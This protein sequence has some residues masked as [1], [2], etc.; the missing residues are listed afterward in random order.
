MDASNTGY[1]APCEANNEEWCPPLETS[2]FGSASILTCAVEFN[3]SGIDVDVGSLP[4]SDVVETVLR[5]H[6]I[7][8]TAT[9]AIHTIQVVNNA[10]VSSTPA[11]DVD[12]H[13][14]PIIV[15]AAAVVVIAAAIAIVIRLRQANPKSSISPA[16]TKWLGSP[17]HM[18][19]TG[20]SGPGESKRRLLGYPVEGGDSKTSPS[21]P[22][23]AAP[24][25][26]ASSTLYRGG[27]VTARIN[28]GGKGRGSI[29]PAAPPAR[30][31]APLR[32]KSTRTCTP[33]QFDQ[34]LDA[35][36]L[37]FTENPV[38]HDAVAAAG[39]PPP[40]GRRVAI[41]SGKIEESSAPVSVS[42]AAVR[43][44]SF[45][46][47]NAAGPSKLTPGMLS[48]QNPLNVSVRTFVDTG[49]GN[50]RYMLPQSSRR[51]VKNKTSLTRG[52]G[53]L[54]QI[55]EPSSAAPARRPSGVGIPGTTKRK[56][57]IAFL[58]QNATG[59][60]TLSSARRQSIRSIITPSTPS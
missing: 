9:I 5:N 39:S 58:P 42:A 55:I 48:N 27:R 53:G 6:S 2:S 43:R 35:S 40:T 51:E 37:E 7:D 19:H 29:A 4:L 50:R 38:A 52:R 14:L 54:Q 47:S 17:M 30:V 18:P 44:G 23:R 13:F 16:P 26:L 46:T 45:F 24:A 11:V 34:I 57:I 15:T 12:R 56:S 31:S 8:A 41:S 60:S 1:S 20:K 49:A 3:A 21:T 10:P 36:N 59:V 28:S 25:G 33:L 32:S 22:L